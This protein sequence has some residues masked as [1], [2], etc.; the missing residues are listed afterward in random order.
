M[1]GLYIVVWG[2][3]K[4]QISSGD[5]SSGGDE[6]FASSMH[7]LPITSVESIEN[8]NKAAEAA[9]GSTDSSGKGALP[10]NPTGGHSKC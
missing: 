2:K 7:E 8:G 1:A 5:T 10:R 9:D 6:N 3:S 4:D